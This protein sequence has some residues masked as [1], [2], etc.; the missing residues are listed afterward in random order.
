MTVTAALQRMVLLVRSYGRLRE[1][2]FSA[3]EDNYETA[4][5]HEGGFSKLAG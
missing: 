3:T 5:T 4:T 2:G 1:G